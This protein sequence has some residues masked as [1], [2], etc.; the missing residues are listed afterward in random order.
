MKS[1]HLLLP[2]PKADHAFGIAG[3][4]DDLDPVDL[5]QGRPLTAVPNP[6]ILE[7]HEASG[8]SK[9]LADIADGLYTVFSPRLRA[10]LVSAGVDNIDYYPA[11]LVHPSLGAVSDDYLLVNVLGLVRA[12][13]EAKSM[14]AAFVKQFT[15]DEHRAGDLRLFRLEESPTL[16]VIDSAVK[17][18]IEKT[19]LDGVFIQPTQAWVGVNRGPPRSP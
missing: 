14:T 4:P 8:Q 12:V 3:G 15:I 19:N 1:Y 9:V 5:I 13:G 2:N 6:V 18:E 11:R 16:I 7:L 10:A 17:A